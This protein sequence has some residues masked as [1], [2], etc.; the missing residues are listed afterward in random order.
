MR[1]GL[2]SQEFSPLGTVE[3]AYSNLCYNKEIF[4]GT[5]LVFVLF[6]PGQGQALSL[7]NKIL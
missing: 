3:E 5:V 2:R 1:Q 4:V 6:E 7:C